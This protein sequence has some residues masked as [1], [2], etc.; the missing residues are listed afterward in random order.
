MIISQLQ[1]TE[2]PTLPSYVTLQ[3][4]YRQDVFINTGVTE[5]FPHK[6]P[7]RAAIKR[8]PLNLAKTRNLCL[9]PSVFIYFK[10]DKNPVCPLLPSLPP[11]L[12]LQSPGTEQSW[13][14]A[15]LISYNLNLGETLESPLFFIVFPLCTKGVSDILAFTVLLTLSATN[16]TLTRHLSLQ[17]YLYSLPSD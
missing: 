12:H 15:L 2:Q 7:W 4:G 17:L 9:F 11:S 5:T 8:V 6:Q 16:V 10:L 3:C 13:L 14:C 1:N